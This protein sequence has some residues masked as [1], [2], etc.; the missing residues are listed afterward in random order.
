MTGETLPDREMLAAEY[1]LGTL[2]G[3]E[4]AQLEAE[5]VR[6]PELRR[7]VAQWEERLLPLA[8]TVAP[9]E[10][11][12][13]L[14][15]RI[16]AATEPSNAPS[17]LSVR[18]APWL[19]RPS[20]AT[21]LWESLLLWRSLAAVAVTAAV[22][23]AVLAVT[24]P[25]PSQPVLIAALQDISKLRRG[26]PAFTVLILSPEQAIVTSVDG[27]RPPTDKV[28]QLWALRGQSALV[29]LGL[30]EHGGL[31]PLSLEQEQ[32][33][34]LHSGDMLEVSLEPPGGSPTDQPTGPIVF[35]GILLT[36]LEAQ[37]GLIQEPQEPPLAGAR[38]R[39]RGL[40]IQEPQ[41]PPMAGAGER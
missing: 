13:D 4:R 8:I 18:Q 40:I 12:P 38:E 1:A 22:M 5:L 7:L 29:S 11:S 41:E 26:E 32:S 14:W 25:P 10:P 20:L 24:P 23:F 9:I 21:R 19:V 36:P 28:F 31:I 2:R 15:A 37:R 6:D 34:R 30:I 17:P 35:A 33:S 39:W 16:A 27:M 3:S